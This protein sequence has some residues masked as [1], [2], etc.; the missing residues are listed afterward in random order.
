MLAIPSYHVLIL[1]NWVRIRIGQGLI[2]LVLGSF[3]KEK[4][5]DGFNKS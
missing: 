1:K 2:R 3:K 4:N 5:Y